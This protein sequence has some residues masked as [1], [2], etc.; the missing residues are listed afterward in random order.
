[1]RRLALAVTLALT[2]CN[3]PSDPP[4]PDDDNT[5]PVATIDTPDGD[6]A[7]EEGDSVN[8]AGTCTDPDEDDTLTHSWD[9][10]DETSTDA[11]P[12]D[13]LLPVG[14]LTVTYSCSDGVET[15]DSVSVVVTVR[16]TAA[17]TA[18][19]ATID[20]PD[21]N[22]AVEEGDSV[23]F[24]GTCS[25]PDEDE[26]LTHAW[27]F[28]DETSTDADPG[29]ILL[30][31][32]VHTV[33]YS[34][35]DGEQTS[36]SSSVVVTVSAIDANTA[37]VA[38]ID[39]PDG[40]LVVEEG[41]SVAF[42]GT[43][44]DPDEDETLTHAWD[45][46]ATT[47]TDADP[48]DILLPVGVHT[49]TYRCSDDDSTSA[50]AQ[51]VVT[52]NAPPSVQIDAP[53]TDV[54]L[55]EGQLLELEATCTDTE[56]PLSHAWSL[57]QTVEDPGFV[58]LPAVGVYEV[59]YTCTDALGA[60]S[61]TSFQ[62]LVNDIPSAQIDAPAEAVI[63]IA[64][65]DDVTFSG[66]CSDSDAT[67][68]PDHDWSFDGAGTSTAEDPGEIA[69]STPGL[70]QV[71][72]RCTDEHG[73]Q[74]AEVTRDVEVNG[75][76]SGTI[77]QP[78]SDLTV[79]TG[80]TVA[81]SSSCSDPE[82]D[83][84]VSHLWSFDG[85]AA[86]A[87]SAAPSILFDAA[88]EFEVTYTCSD[89]LGAADLTAATVTITVNGAPVAS[90]DHPVEV[91]LG[92][93]DSLSFSGTC[94]DADGP[95]DL[96][97]EW[98]FDTHLDFAEVEDPGERTFEVPGDFEVAYTCT[99]EL[100][101][102]DTATKLVH[103][104]PLHTIGGRV[105]GYAG[106]GLVLQNNGGDDLP[107]V[108]SED[109]TFSLP[110]REGLDYE[111]TVASSPSGPA[112]VCDVYGGSGTVGSGDVRDVL[113]YCHSE[114]APFFVTPTGSGSS[115]GSSW[116]NA[117]TIGQLAAMG[118]GQVAWVQ[119]GVYRNTLATPSTTPVANL[120]AGHAIYG[121]FA[122]TETTFAER[123][124]LAPSILDGDVNDDDVVDASDTHPV[125][126]L[127]DRTEIDGFVVREGNAN[128]VSTAA[129]GGGAKVVFAST[130]TF[131]DVTFLENHGA[132]GAAIEVQ[133]SSHATILGCRFIANVATS[134]SGNSGTVYA[135][136]ASLT[137]VDSL[138]YRNQAEVG[139]AVHYIRFSSA[140]VLAV[141]RTAFIQNSAQT[142]GAM[143]IDGGDAFLDDNL[144]LD[145]AATAVN[146]V[147]GALELV[148]GFS[149]NR[150][151]HINGTIFAENQAN[152][153]GGAIL[154]DDVETVA[155]DVVFWK[156]SA[157]TSAGGALQ[158]FN[159]AFYGSQVSAT[160]NT[161]GTSGP[162]AQGS[163]TV[164]LDRSAIYHPEGSWGSNVFSDCDDTCI[165]SQRASNSDSALT[166]LDGS[167][168]SLGN[169]FLAT[170]SGHLFLAQEDA[171]DLF[172]S[173][174]VD[175]GSAIPTETTWRSTTTRSD[176]ALDVPQIDRGAHYSPDAAIIWEAEADASTLLWSTT[177]A[178]ECWL[179]SD[180]DETADLLPPSGNQA[181]GKPAGA[182][183]ALVCMGGTGA[184]AA[185]VLETD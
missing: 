15:S 125:V 151:V 153:R 90:I 91:S 3:G 117:A 157:V 17:N 56:T 18:P 8:F 185:V 112:Q 135:G 154:F 89:S 43:C 162:L 58:A 80:D 54:V 107:L 152:S 33:T 103:V 5:A 170:P 14:V 110:V 100:G 137:I 177:G 160:G 50:V 161:Q 108:R 34:C 64:E 7:V 168:D 65:G 166:I 60:A 145:N 6:I 123:A 40:D 140:S 171:G 73:A 30:P 184:P 102:S 1:V 150:Q 111:I 134:A 27:D 87:T 167:T 180:A 106:S 165:D 2:A 29:D 109:F 115:D 78:A 12:G 57:G 128:G 122:G 79:N 51:V 49:V 46:G 66:T 44:T 63:A 97:H 68:A 77:T 55:N 104:L 155:R 105:T 172:T 67:A 147:G 116:E 53:L 119:A 84:A 136:S 148:S 72:Y 42:A 163:I 47:S 139:G 169:P 129:F 81:F 92:V 178:S 127:D 25:D 121:G 101:L 88:G 141:R 120:T 143:R 62:L 59:T 159:R 173:A 85:A 158:G 174:C 16:A 181:H 138:F 146:G 23:N 39:A 82:L 48:G 32:G 10:G 156:N 95:G 26:T 45:F 4:P 114:G 142:S 176:L 75:R 41:E 164:S 86:D 22:I 118:P 36:D 94:A 31:V 131:A 98:Q 130:A 28:G 126:L 61:S 149:T 93:G 124:G 70:Y 37:P 76:P 132:A 20:A 11:D 24:A 175:A 133:G 182:V 9:F 69:F 13:I 99:D 113:I 179:Y 38:T 83:E 52:V 19:V 96:L 144:F 71:T 74:S 183:L 21:G 35:S